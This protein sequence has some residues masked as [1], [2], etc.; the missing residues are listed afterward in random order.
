MKK[1]IKIQSSADKYLVITDDSHIGDILKFKPEY[2]GIDNTEILKELV[3][4]NYVAKAGDR[5]V[6]TRRALWR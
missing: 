3:R 6:L 5:Y 1:K 2:I 4:Y